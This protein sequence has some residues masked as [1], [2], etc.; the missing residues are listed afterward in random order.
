MSLYSADRGHFTDG[1]LRA[2]GDA[3]DC[4][5][6]VDDA[7]DYRQAR[8][9]FHFIPCADHGQESLEGFN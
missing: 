3:T 1:C 9:S 8:L 4:V 2:F 5:I 7:G 6:V